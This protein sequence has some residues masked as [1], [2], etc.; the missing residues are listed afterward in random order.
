ML[1]LKRKKKNSQKESTVHQFDVTY[2]IQNSYPKISGN[3][4]FASTK[5]SLT[6]VDKQDIAQR[7]AR[8]A[9]D[10]YSDRIPRDNISVAITNISYLGPIAKSD[11]ERKVASRGSL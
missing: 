3:T 8:S 5:C 1:R 6:P 4:V 7:I 11:W 10:N 9:M 2:V